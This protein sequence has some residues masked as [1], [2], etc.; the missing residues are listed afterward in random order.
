MKGPEIT[1]NTL[2]ELGR[3]LE[4]ATL[5]FEKREGET[6]LARLAETQAL[7]AL[8]EAQKAFDTCIA[9]IR[10]TSPQASEWKRN[11]GEPA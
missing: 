7:N 11:R 2:A 6:R 4:I 1:A 10:K 9:E 5:E 8:N 3:S